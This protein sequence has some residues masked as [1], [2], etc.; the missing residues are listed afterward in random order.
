MGRLSPH[1]GGRDVVREQVAH[2][3]RLSEH[4]VSSR[5]SSRMPRGGQRRFGWSVQG[6]QGQGGE[7]GFPEAPN[8]GRLELDAEEVMGLRNRFDRIG[9]AA[10][11]VETSRALLKGHDGEHLMAPPAAL[12]ARARQDE[13][14][15]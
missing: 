14:P 1:V 10:L 15:R 2:L 9:A 7:I 3:I 8:G 13:L 5:G 4:R 6:P 12:L 11:P